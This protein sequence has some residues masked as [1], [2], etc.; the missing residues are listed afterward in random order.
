MRRKRHD[1]RAWGVGACVAGV[2]VELELSLPLGEQ[3]SE[4]DAKRRTMTELR[5]DVFDRQQIRK[6]VLA[7]IGRARVANQS[8]LLQIPQVILGDGWIQLADGAKTV[9]SAA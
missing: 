3:R 7:L 2:E 1:F 8:P 6:R 5:R 9:G 4:N